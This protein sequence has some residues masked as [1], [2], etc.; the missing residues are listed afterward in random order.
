MGCAI[1][2]VFICV[3]PQL[4]SLWP[5]EL[6]THGHTNGASFTDPVRRKAI[7][8]GRGG[9]MQAMHE[10]HCLEEHVFLTTESNTENAL[11]LRRGSHARQCA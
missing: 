4:L 2:F 11:F 6:F 1:Q 3:S 9:G 8:R 10:L 5:G 7:S